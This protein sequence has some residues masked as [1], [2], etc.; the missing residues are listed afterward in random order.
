M[1]IGLGL[2]LRQLGG[3]TGASRLLGAATDGLAIDFR[4]MS[5]VIRD[6]ATPANNFSGDPNSKLTYSSPFTKWIRGSNNLYSSGTT[7][8]TEFNSSASPLG[9]RVE[10]SATNL[11]TNNRSPTGTRNVTVTAQAYTLAFNGTGTITLSGASTA[12]PLVGTGVNDRVSLTFTPS[13]GTLTLTISGSIDHAQLETGSV[14]TSP[15]ETAGAAV[16][17][18]PDAISILTSAFS[19][20]S[21]IGT[22]AVTFT[23]FDVNNRPAYQFGSGGDRYILFVQSGTTRNLIFIGGSA[24]VA[25]LDHSGSLPA[26]TQARIA[27]AWQTGSL[28]SSLNGAAAITSS[29][30]FSAFGSGN[31]LFIGGGE[32]NFFNGHIRSLVH[33]PRRATNVEIQTLGA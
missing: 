17:R 18:L 2:G 10:P 8:R 3:S 29:N 15:V 14:A 24:V 1:F 23:P 30:A 4:D 11:F 26:N 32:G 5:M 21:T 33:L 27:T 31:S 20:S 12:G 16:T 6:T 13:A 25:N 9:I 22:A 28:A 7:L 19:Y